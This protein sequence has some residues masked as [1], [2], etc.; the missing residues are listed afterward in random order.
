MHD[1]F[2]R[3]GGGLRLHK[4]HFLI[5]HNPL[6]IPFA[7]FTNSSPKVFLS[8][9][10]VLREEIKSGQREMRSIICAFRSEL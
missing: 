2:F 7:C 4:F 1:L 8:N 5:F 9:S 3:F 6:D 10:L